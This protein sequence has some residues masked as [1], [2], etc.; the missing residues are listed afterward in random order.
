MSVARVRDHGEV[1]TAAR[2]VA[3]VLDLLP[4]GVVE[5][6]WTVWEPGVG[7]GN[8]MLAVA[9]RMLSGVARSETSSRRCVQALDVAARLY[10]AD[11]LDDNLDR[12]RA[13]LAGLFYGWAI[14]GRDDGWFLGALDEVLGANLVLADALTGLA[15]DGTPAYLTAWRAAREPLPGASA[16]GPTRP[17]GPAGPPIALREAL[18]GPALGAWSG[19]DLVV[20]N[21][22]YQ[23]PSGSATSDSSLYQWF[24][25]QAVALNPRHVVML[26]PARWLAAGKAM[27]DFRRRMLRDRRLRR[28]LDWPLAVE[29]FPG[30]KID[31]GVL[32]FAWDREHD[33]DCLVA[34]VRGGVI[35]EAVARRLDEH[36]VFVRD[37]RDVRLLR[38]V[39]R[40]IEA[41][42]LPSIASGVSYQIPFG[43][44]S[45]FVGA[46]S[47]EGLADPVLVFGRR[48]ETS[49]AERSQVLRNPDWIGSWKVLVPKA[50]G[51][52]AVPAQVLGHPFVVGPDAVCTQTYLVAGRFETEAQADRFA[53]LLRTRFV[54][55]LV[56]VQKPTADLKPSRFSFVPALT[57]D[58]TWT[59]EAL[60]A[61]FGLDGD[62][63]AWVESRVKAM[64]ATARRSRALTVPADGPLIEA[65]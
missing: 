34:T 29:C 18:A 26:I 47:P 55:W 9:A 20:G 48:R 35:G 8:F 56:G 3:D 12:A 60:Y 25:D 28:L 41:R 19:F 64:P 57:L 13:R 61:E 53:A 63:V 65:A 44:K 31:G 21:P 4:G 46:A 6:S 11:L 33:G 17:T 42:S 27:D 43:L 2:E 1:Y 50:Y 62:D 22:P 38:K 36:D 39:Q 24:V 52:H 32:A 59:D 37:A 16:A 49:W 40:Q 51:E 58:R 14:P 54:R 5:P 15:P 30:T 10:G 23:A 45:T 7:T